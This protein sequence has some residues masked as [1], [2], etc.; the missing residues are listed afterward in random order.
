M[1]QDE[2]VQVGNFLRNRLQNPDSSGN[3]F[4]PGGS[5]NP[6][7]DFLE[8]GRDR[9]LDHLTLPPPVPFE[10][11]PKINFTRI[12]APQP[13]QKLSVPGSIPFQPAPA[14]PLTHPA[15]P[16]PSQQPGTPSVLSFEPAPPHSVPAALPPMPAPKQVGPSVLPAMP[17]P[18]SAVRGVIPPMPAPKPAGPS[19]LPAQPAP[20]SGGPARLPQMPAPGAKGP[21]PSVL[22]PP[23]QIS[24]SHPPTSYGEQNDIILD[25]NR[26]PHSSNLSPLARLDMVDRQV[27]GFLKVIDGTGDP[28]GLDPTRGPHS[29]IGGSAPGTQSWNPRL[30]AR[31]LVNVGNSLGA[32]GIARFAATQL[33]LFALNRH[34]KIWNPLTGAPPP[35]T[36]NFIPAALDVLTGTPR[37]LTG[38]NDTK[39][40]GL[41]GLPGGQ[42]FYEGNVKSP[43]GDRQLQLAQGKYS[44][45][46]ILSYP[47][48]V[49]LTIDAGATGPTNIMNMLS[50]RLVGANSQDTSFVDN[51]LLPDA[52][53]TLRES[54][55]QSRN[56]WSDDSGLTGD[57]NK[58]TEQSADTLFS[59][60][61]LV[62]GTDPLLVDNPDIKGQKRVAL[63]PDKNAGSYFRLKKSSLSNIPLEWRPKENLNLRSAKLSKGDKLIAS[64]FRRGII[65]ADFGV[66]DNH[67]FIIST[68]KVTDGPSSKI[69]DDDAYV[70]LSFMDLRPLGGSNNV[71]TVY[72]RPFIT[73]LTEEISPEWNKQNF[74]GRVDPVMTY[75]STNRTIS[76]SF[77]VQAFSPEDL[78]TIYYKLN[79]L[80]S[81]CYPSYDKDLLFKS[82]PSVRMRVGDLIKGAG[83]L[84]LPGVIENISAEYTDSLWELKKNN[85]VPMGFRV[86]LS[87]QVLH[88]VPI[89]IGID[90]K[91]GGIGKI[92][93]DGNFSYVPPSSQ[94]SSTGGDSPKPSNIQG[95]TIDSA[96]PFRGGPGNGNVPGND[97]NDYK[98]SND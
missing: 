89:G 43:D 51:P 88:E 10:L 83:S 82:G 17:A 53:I 33:G 57:D 59:M 58:Y 2:K 30:F 64:S 93:D 94:G 23:P 20:P 84:G 37:A 6:K 92:G 45:T 79:W 13:S 12:A 71:R 21:S 55:A 35:L 80:S 61:D 19:V 98:L 63:D 15:A 11:A 72:F 38:Y 32:A 65:P 34:G 70:P 96:D 49:G 74:F 44:E 22:Q 27:K 29:Q 41:I 24:R 85:K 31:W 26:R 66:N 36:E 42:G 9:D 69:D 16:Q 1:A 67:G 56:F 62:D 77:A 3:P 81:M 25:D 60:S 8:T 52:S 14:I 97:M 87:F 86:S 18:A 47:P 90:G 50:P 54:A 48:F 95:A 78:K 4:A 91:F 68:S 5:V 73:S 28:L 39:G 7:K 75:M 46:Q 40:M 76:I